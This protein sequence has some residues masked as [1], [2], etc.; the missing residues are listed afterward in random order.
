MKG[1]LEREFKVG[2]LEEKVRKWEWGFKRD[3][4]SLSTSRS[5]VAIISRS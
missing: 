3:N 2:E 1:F 5:C 4:E